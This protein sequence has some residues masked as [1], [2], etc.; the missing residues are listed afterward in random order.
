MGL[1]KELIDI[2][3]TGASRIENVTRG[4]QEFWIKRPEALPFKMRLQKGDPFKAFAAEIEAHKRFEDLG[5][6]VPRIVASGPDFVITE[7]AGPSINTL[8]ATLS[9]SDQ[10]TVLFRAGE[11]L[12]SWHRKGFG[13]GRPSLKDMC[14]QDG[15]ITFLDFERAGDKRNGVGGQVMDLLILLFSTS[16]ETG[17]ENSAMAAVR[18]GYLS[19]GGR[20][21]W[22]RAKA[23]LR[24]LTPLRLALRPVVWVLGENREFDAIEP[25]FKFLDGDHGA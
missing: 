5:L 14:W 7:G 23:R 8:L 20:S 3:K 18:D 11:A 21:N 19:A 16:V 22:R 12:A 2:A 25:F 15:K 4:G 13:H 10:S 17:G 6:P 24:W 1:T 9:D